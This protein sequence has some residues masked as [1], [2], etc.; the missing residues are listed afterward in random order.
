MV[1]KKN[2]L[3]TAG[4]KTTTG[5]RAPDPTAGGGGA[6]A[7]NHLL[8]G[9]KGR[10]ISS[11]MVTFAAQGAQAVLQVG[12]IVVLA[13]LLTPVDFGLLG[14]VL[15]ITGFLRVFNDA[16]LSTATVQREGITEAQVSN[17]FWTNVALGGLA[18]GLLA[19]AAPLVA[20][21]YKEPRLVAVTL[22]VSITFLLTGATVQHLALL[23]RQMRF[24]A[25]AVIQTI[26]MAMGVVVATLMAW[27]GCGY[28]SLVGMQVAPP[29]LT[30]VLTWT[31][32]RWRPHLPQRG[33]GMGELLGFGA[34]L[35]A[36]SFLWSLA[37]GS[38][39]MLIGKV[40]GA[41][42]L[43]LYT[44]AASLFQRPV[45]LFIDPL[46]YVIVPTLSRL[47]SHPERYHRTY[48]RVFELVAVVSFL[49]SGLLLAL[50]KPMT[51]VLLGAKWGEAASISA[52]LTL[53]A[54]YHPIACAN[55]WL[56]TSQCRGREALILSII[57]SVAAVISFL[58]GLRFGPVGVALCYSISCLLVRLP[59]AFYIT[60]RQG[61]VG[62]QEQW[63]R[64]LTHLPVW[65]IVCGST[66]VI[67]KL[68]AEMK[69]MTQLLICVPAGLTVGAAFIFAYPPARRSI[70]GLVEALREFKKGRA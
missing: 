68:V 13:R 33:H 27:L 59:V 21:F 50:A 30:F 51:L 54:M 2:Q 15:Y 6:F 60:G 14:M 3:A 62:T 43:G 65:V 48:M 28:W 67:Q 42:S 25:I 29:L 37:K 12:S 52:S 44:R 36:S 34:N 40:Y 61:P 64:F 53:V 9:I 55:G 38:D 18:T 10:T 45:E 57:S 23:K 11:S 26:A 31:T 39:A 1:P 66:V 4:P 41:A 8:S 46:N 56:L 20:W 22:A 5:A 58:I 19:A 47:Q 49:L 69:P 16:G 70:L 32:S 35:T 24:G 17:L 63:S 7:T